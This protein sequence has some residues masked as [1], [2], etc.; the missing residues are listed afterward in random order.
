VFQ[1]A[2]LAKFQHLHGGGEYEDMVDV[3]EGHDPAG[4][5]PE[6]SWAKGRIFRC[7]SCAEEIRVLAPDQEPPSER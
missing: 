6:R 2:E 5:D 3:T 4:L 7:M 1:F